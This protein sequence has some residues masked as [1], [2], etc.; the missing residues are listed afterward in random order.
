MTSDDIAGKWVKEAEE[1]GELKRSKNF[2]K[3]LDLRDGFAQTPEELKIAFKVLKN[4]GF[5]PAEVGLFR[6]LE[7]LRKKIS[8]ETDAEERKALQKQI[9]NKQLKIQIFAEQKKL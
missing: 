9:A 1:S 3:P 4:S 6:E 2:G 8:T 7:G 5:I